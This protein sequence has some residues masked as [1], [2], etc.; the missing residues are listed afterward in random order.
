MDLLL[1][2]LGQSSFTSKIDLRK[3]Y[4]Q[5]EMDQKSITYTAFICD[6]GKYEFLRMP[7]GLKPNFRRS[8]EHFRR[9]LS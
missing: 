2:K 5:I 8:Q 9:Y 3:G 6:E 7:F 1:G 4:W